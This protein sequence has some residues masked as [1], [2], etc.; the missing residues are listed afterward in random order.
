MPRLKRNSIAIARASGRRSRGRRPR[1]I[2]GFARA[3]KNIRKDLT[4]GC[5]GARWL[6]WLQ[7][8]EKVDK[9]GGFGIGRE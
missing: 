5:T 1:R 6:Q 8:L 2:S 4:A 7:M 9:Q 3:V